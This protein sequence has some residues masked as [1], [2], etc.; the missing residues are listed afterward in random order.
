MKRRRALGMSSKHEAHWKE[1]HRR[2]ALGESLNTAEKAVYEAGCREMDA[3]EWLDGDLARLRE[4][5]NGIVEAEREQQR[6]RDREAEL[7][8]RIA[9][10]EA[11]LDERTRR[12]LGIQL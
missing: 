10:L 3:E 2:V 12:L 7:D 6:L 9:D 1:L 4:L 8:D 11:R 5:R